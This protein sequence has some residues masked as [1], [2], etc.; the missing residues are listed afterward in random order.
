MSRSWRPGLMQNNLLLSLVL[1]IVSLKMVMATFLVSFSNQGEGETFKFRVDSTTD[2]NTEFSS[3]VV[4]SERSFGI[5]DMLM[6]KFEVYDGTEFTAFDGKTLVREIVEKHSGKHIRV[7]ITLPKQEKGHHLAISGKVF[8]LQDGMMPLIVDDDEAVVHLRIP[9]VDNIDRGD[10]DGKT[11]LS[12]WDA[13]LCLAQF[14]SLSLNRKSIVEGKVV[15]ELGAGTGV[16]GLSAAFLGARSVRLTDLGYAL[17]NLRN[18]IKIN[19]E[20]APSVEVKVGAM[21]LDWTDPDTWPTE[22]IDLVLAADVAWLDHLVTPLAAT[23][24]GLLAKNPAAEMYLAHQTRS[25][26]VD[27]ALFHSLRRTSLSPRS[28]GASITEITLRRK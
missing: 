22:P 8:S 25:T 28:T 21:V 18:N 17:D 12:T 11:G 4:Q 15:V 27:E 20:A 14:L 10:L 7:S 13:S 23:I 6:S 1:L 26:S 9:E 24:K 2:M 3:F 19:T 16:S 5:E